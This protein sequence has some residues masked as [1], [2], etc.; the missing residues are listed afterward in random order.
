MGAGEE[1]EDSSVRYAAADVGTVLTREQKLEARAW[2]AEQQLLLAG[3][4]EN[5]PPTHAPPNMVKVF[6][7]ACSKR[8][9]K[10]TALQLHE[11]YVL[12]EDGQWG[13]IFKEGT[14]KA[15]GD[16]ARSPEGRFVI[17]ADRPPIA[18]TKRVTFDGSR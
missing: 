4:N 9:N 14:C 3:L 1:E 18:A 7:H 10:S 16:T 11:M 17:A 12:S 15:C 2:L 8:R 5:D 13:F 6:R